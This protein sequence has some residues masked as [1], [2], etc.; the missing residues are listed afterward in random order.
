MRYLDSTLFR[1]IVLELEW[2]YRSVASNDAFYDADAQ[3]YSV[4]V[5][6]GF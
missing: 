5:Q 2:L 4:G 1:E 3:A 6:F